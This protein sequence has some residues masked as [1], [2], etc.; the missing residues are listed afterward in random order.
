VFVLFYRICQKKR[1]KTGNYQSYE[2]SKLEEA[3]S[4]VKNGQ[5]SQRKA[6]KFYS[7]TQATV[8]DHIRG[9]VSDGALPCRQ[10]VIHRKSEI[11]Q[12]ATQAASMGMGMSKLQL[13]HKVGRVTKELKLKTPLKKMYREKTGGKV[14]LNAIPP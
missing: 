3:L 6:A 5:L 7:I 2:D 13:L 8:S 10:P 14:L 1:V 9:R 12:R 4:A 11:A